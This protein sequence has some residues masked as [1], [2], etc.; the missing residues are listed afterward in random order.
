MVVVPRSPGHHRK[1]R[2]EDERASWRVSLQA[3]SPF[4]I[5]NAAVQSKER[6][7]SVVFLG[8]WTKNVCDLEDCESKCVNLTDLA[9]RQ[10]SF[11]L[12]WLC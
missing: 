6:W 4:C 1:S 5:G 11:R 2:D 12:A 10:K 9:W 3:T 8:S 7:L